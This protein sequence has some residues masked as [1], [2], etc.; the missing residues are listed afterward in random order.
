M[1]KQHL[2]NPTVNIDMSG[3]T[4]LGASGVTLA[5]PL[6]ILLDDQHVP[7][8]PV[9]VY[10]K[11]SRI[12]VGDPKRSNKPRDILSLGPKDYA[13]ECAGWT[14]TEHVS[15]LILHDPYYKVTHVLPWH[16]ILKIEIDDI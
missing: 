9:K 6:P 1:A 13:G 7:M 16:N 5:E 14:L 12:R 11:D 4:G 8:Q 2:D 15:G 10:T 3:P